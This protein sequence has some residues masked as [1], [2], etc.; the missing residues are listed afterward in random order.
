MILIQNNSQLQIIKPNTFYLIT[1]GTNRA[2]F[3]WVMNGID[4]RR[5]E[6]VDNGTEDMT[7]IAALAML[8]RGFVDGR[9]LLKGD[10]V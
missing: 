2:A 5:E 8:T 10:I 3:C 9:S 1:I 4:A 7:V 6:A